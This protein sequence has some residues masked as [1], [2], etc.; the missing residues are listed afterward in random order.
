MKNWVWLVFI[1]VFLIACSNSEHAFSGEELSSN[2]F[3]EDSLVQLNDLYFVKASGFSV[4]MGTN[5]PDA[6]VN[7]RPAMQVDFSYDFYLTKHEITCGEFNS[8]MKSA[9][10]LVLDCATETLPATNLTYYDAVLYANERSKENGLDTAYTYL[11]RTFDSENHC[12]NLE[13]F[14]YHPE[15]ETFRLPTE[16]EWMFAAQSNWN[17]KKAWTV[18]NSQSTLHP[19]CS[20]ANKNE[21]CDMMGNALEWVND[22]FGL[23]SDTTVQNYVGAPDGGTLSQRIVKG[24]SFRSQ[25]SSITLHAR[26]DI[27]SVTSSTRADYVG[28][29]LAYGKIPD[30]VWI[31]S[32]GR[33]AFSRTVPLANT[34]TLYLHTKTYKT[35]LVFRNDVSGN[36][37]YV[38][39][40]NGILSVIEIIDTLDAY[41]PDIS[42][43][44]NRVAFC[45]KYEGVE[46][47]SELYVRDLN[48]EGSNLVKLNVE[49]AAIPRWRVLENGD[50]VI[51]Y[52]TDAGN[53][54][55]EATFRSTSTWQVKFSNGEF[56]EP[57]KLFDGAYHGGVSTDNRLAVSGARI[58]RARVDDHDTVWYNGEQ[59]CNVSLLQD[60]SNRT[61]FLDFGSATGRDFVGKRYATHERLFVADSLGRLIQSIGAP[62]GY[63]FDHTE[64][65]SGLSDLA[66]ATLTNANGSHRKIVLIDLRDSSV[67]DLAEGDELWHPNMWAYSA[68]LILDNKSIDL[69]SAALYFENVSDPLLSY[70]M[71]IFWSTY[72]SL[73][74]VGLGSSRMSLGFNSNE[75]TYGK[76]FNMAAIPSDMDIS[77]YLAQYYVFNH[78]SHLKALVVGIDFDLWFDAENA[79]VMKSLLSFPGYI[80][81]V[82]HNFWIDGNGVEELK[83]I[84]KKRIEEVDVLRAFQQSMGWVNLK[85]G[86]SWSSIGFN[87]NLVLQ[88]S[89]W[90]DNPLTYRRAMN[91]LEF[92]IQLAEEK[93]IRVV[94]VIFPQSPEYKETGAY[95]KHGMRRSHAI[96]LIEEVQDLERK[97]DNFYLMDE[98]KMGDHDYVDSLAYDSDHLNALGAEQMTARIDS[99]LK[100]MN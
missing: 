22:W 44:G 47:K 98:N 29:R 80:Y 70:K 100:S 18:E 12:V 89:A 42:P 55:N 41:H 15:I 73:E 74:V 79:T 59:A 24:G 19:V 68:P 35:K 3:V 32:D 49:S 88:D 99:V 9:T 77:L 38:V 50:T 81:D 91:N 58:L 13:G 86:F 76:A 40:S 4:E 63:T 67:V 97:Y 56:G 6:N 17:A 83:T 1:S 94:G 72:D 20:K 46:G 28:F 64:W 65:V 93:G 78:C 96:K 69:D 82:D 33:I 11:S 60:G 45:T 26:G 37:A 54:K 10:G 66:V 21:L 57:Q 8:L 34:S 62:A 5:L 71:N 75:I 84:S 87:E 31:G 39:Y 25:A 53:N 52:V 61:L 48:E 23:F 30:A 92:L 27:Y 43:D 7:D 14:V 90:S 95:G 2:S 85:E 16:A 36:L 51:V